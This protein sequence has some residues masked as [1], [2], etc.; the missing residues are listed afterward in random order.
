MEKAKKKMEELVKICDEEGLAM[1]L[2]VA[3]MST[4]QSEHGVGGDMGHLFAGIVTLVL[5]IVEDSGMSMK[6]ARR[7]IDHALKTAR[8]TNA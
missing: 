7:V 4:N 5:H 8:K 6:E 1:C 2:Y 3:D